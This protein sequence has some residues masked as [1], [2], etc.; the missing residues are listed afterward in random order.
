MPNSVQELR[1]AKRVNFA[2]PADLAI[3]RGSTERIEKAVTIDL[4]ELG[5]CVRVCA[6]IAPG[7]VVNL[8]LTRRPEPCRV[9][10]TRATGKTAELLAGL[11]FVYSLPDP[12]RATPPSGKYEPIN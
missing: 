7:Q 2:A 11:E 1:R 3:A 6:E 12:R 5:V 8:F 4:S 9:V 10:W